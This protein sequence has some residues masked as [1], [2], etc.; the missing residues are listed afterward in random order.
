MMPGTSCIFRGPCTTSVC[1]KNLVSLSLINMKVKTISRLESDYTRERSNDIFKVQRNRDPTLHPFERAREYTRALNAVK[2][3]RLFAK[4]FVRAL[5]GHQ[6]GV[7]CLARHPSRITT[8]VSGSADGEVRVWNNATGNVAWLLRPAHKGFVRGIA[9]A[10]TETNVFFTC[11]DDKVVRMWNGAAAG[12]LGEERDQ[13]APSSSSSPFVLDTPTTTAPTASQTFQPSA[14]PLTSIDHHSTR[15]LFATTSS[16]VELWE[17]SRLK[18]IRRFEWG[19]ESLSA[20]KFNGTHG[21]VLAACG[22]DRT[23]T[24]YDV[25]QEKA[26]QKVVLAMRSN[27]ISWNPQEPFNFAVANEDHNAYLFDMRNLA[28]SRLI[29][30]DHVSAVIDIDFSPTGA[31]LATAS[32]DRTLR[33]FSAN[34]GHSRD[35]YHTQRMQRVTAVRWSLDARWVFSGS[36][37]GNVRVWRGDAGSRAATQTPR[38]QTAS[39]YRATLASR[40]S[41]LPEIR[42][43]ANHRRVPKA[44][45]V[46]KRTKED[47]EESQKRKLKN[48]E[49]HSKPGTVQWKAERK[50]SIVE[51]EQ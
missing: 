31:E 26:V 7:Y 20:V 13:A 15:P 36:D 44:V 12:E 37:E 9:F 40:F 2:L 28:Q 33:I 50:K 32:W 19:C 24:V 48:F 38:Q 30:K 43:I 46:A 42:R 22:S 4:P 6:D 41:H 11:G 25:R 47:M 51:V 45:T 23:V 16:A 8:L 34:T 49:K 29:Y 17:H 35:V 1:A 18:P 5:E 21:D 3:E 27:A 10:P 14:A 39:S